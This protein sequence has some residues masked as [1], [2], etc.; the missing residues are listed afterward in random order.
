MR[1]TLK[2]IDELAGDL[3]SEASASRCS[4]RNPDDQAEI[5][6]ELTAAAEV[7]L[8]QARG[9][10]LGYQCGVVHSKVRALI[11]RCS[12][13]SKDFRREL[14]ALNDVRDAIAVCNGEPVI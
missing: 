3:C 1:D 12:A 11:D 5:A 7:L 8:V 13:P 6:A 14:Q 2:A 4:K 9:T 10:T